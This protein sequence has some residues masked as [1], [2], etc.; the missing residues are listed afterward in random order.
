MFFPKLEHLFSYPGM[1]E[2]VIK[3]FDQWLASQSEAYY[4]Y[5]NPNAF[6]DESQVNKTISLKIFAL[7][8]KKD[9]F[10]QFNE[11]PLLLIK[12]IVRCPTCDEPY[13][14]FHHKDE[15]PNDFLSCLNDECDN[16][17]PQWIPHR[18]EIFYELKDYPQI[19]DDQLLEVYSASNFPPLFADDRDLNRI[20]FELEENGYND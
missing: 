14:T 18:I 9:Y 12:Y 5:L 4:D 15:I 7:A 17:N 13:K 8:S 11:E 6:I 20:F 1:N 2:Y 3:K 10:I 19:E 16:F